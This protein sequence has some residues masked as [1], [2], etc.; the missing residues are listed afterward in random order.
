M[1]NS[2]SLLRRILYFQVISPFLR[3]GEVFDKLTQPERFLRINVASFSHCSFDLFFLCIASAPY[4]CSCDV[5]AWCNRFISKYFQSS[6][7]YHP[8]R[9]PVHGL[10]SNALPVDV[11][12]PLLLSSA[13]HWQDN[14]RNK[15]MAGWDISLV[16]CYNNCDFLNG[17][18]NDAPVLV[19]CNVER[20]V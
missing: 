9:N 4:R 2:P 5:G 16:F 3:S 20:D 13:H 19:L 6:R 15:R 12:T 11:P 7:R 14:R 1:L 10:L 17:A 8:L 18:G